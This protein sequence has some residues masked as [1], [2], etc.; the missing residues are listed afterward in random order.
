MDLIGIQLA[1]LN[2]LLSVVS[3]YSA[4]GGGWQTPGPRLESKAETR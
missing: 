4:L 1:R 3:L 2:E